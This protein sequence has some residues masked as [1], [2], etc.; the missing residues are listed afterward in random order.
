MGRRTFLNNKG[1]DCQ[2]AEPRQTTDNL[3]PKRSLLR[4]HCSARCCVLILESIPNQTADGMFRNSVD[5]L[6]QQLK[7]GLQLK[8]PEPPPPLL[9]VVQFRRPS[10]PAAEAGRDLRPRYTIWTD[11]SG[12]GR[13]QAQWS[14]NC[15]FHGTLGTTAAS[16]EDA[17]KAVSVPESSRLTRVMSS[18]ASLYYP[19]RVNLSDY[20]SFRLHCRDES[21]SP[22]CWLF[23][24]AT[25]SPVR[26]RSIFYRPFG[27]GPCSPGHRFTTV[28]LPFADFLMTYRGRLIDS[29]ETMNARRILG[30]LITLIDPTPGPFAIVCDRLEALRQHTSAQPYR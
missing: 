18:F 8:S 28:D 7:N 30:F 2:V 9:L 21:E 25:E 22:R 12:G 27:V 29:P 17:T 4:Y 16:V 15:V 6:V 14:N 11:S 24:V 13:S 20:D 23:G 5:R 10:E 1:Q 3:A 19:L 26:E